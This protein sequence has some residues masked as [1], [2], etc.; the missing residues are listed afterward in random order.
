MK[1]TNLAIDLRIAT[2]VLTLISALGG[3]LSY[4]VLPKES[5]PSIEIPNII[6]TT[7]YPGASPADVENLITRRIEREVQTI[8]G[9]DKLRSTSVEGVSTI[10][11]EFTPDVKLDE[12]NQKIREKVDLAKPELPTDVEEPIISEIDLS[13]FPIMAVNLAAG[14]SLARLKDVAEDLKDSIETIPSVLEVD[15]VGGLE[16]EVQVEVDIGKL[17]GYNLGFSDISK[18]IREENTNIPGGSIDVDRLNYLIRIDGQIEHPRELEDLQIKTEDGRSIYIRDVAR[19][20]YGFKDRASHARLRVLR[21]SEPDGRLVEVG[22]PDYTQVITLSVK[23][24]SGTNIIDAADAVRAKIKEFRTPPGTKV[25]ITGDQSKGVRDLVKDLENNIISGLVFVV[26]VLLFFLGVRTSLLVG[27]AIPLSMFISFIVFNAMGQTLNFII[28]FSLIIALGMLVDNAIVIVENI[29]RFLEEGHPPWEAARNGTAEVG[30]AVIAS[31]ATTVAAFIPMLFW[32]GIIGEFMSFMPLTLIVT[33]C[34]SLFVALVI[35]P[36]ITGYFAQVPGTQSAPL[37]RNMRFVIG[38]SVATALIII[39]IARPVTVLVMLGTGLVLYLVHTRILSKVADRFVERG[40]PGLVEAYR[41]FLVLM[42]QRDYDVRRGLLR[43]AFSL[44]AFAGG[45]G[46]LALGGV[47]AGLFGQ[48]AAL[49]LLVPGGILA[50]AGLIGVLVHTFETIALGRMLSV[51]LGLAVTAAMGLALGVVALGRGGLAPEAVVGSLL[52]PV[53]VVVFGLIGALLL[54]G[55][56]RLLLTDNRARLLNTVLGGLIGILV[57]FSVAPTGVE[58]FPETDPNQILITAEARLG[59]NLEAS[60]RVARQ[61]EERLDALLSRSPATERSF[62]N[63]LVNVGVGGDAMFGGGAASPE[64]SRFTLNLVDYRDREE[65]SQ[66]TLARIREE[67]RGLAGVDITIDAD[68][69]GPP[70]GPPVNIELTGPDF[71]EIV[72][73]SAEAQSLLS[74]AAEDGSLPGLVDVRDNLNTGRPELQVR[75]NRERA[76]RFGLSTSKIASTVRTAIAG[77][78]VSKYRDGD[79][80][81]DIRL[82]LREEDRR[83][84][85]ALRQLNIFH[86]GTQI[87]LVSVAELDLGNG[88]GSITRL[89]M[90]RVVTVQGDAAPGVNAPALL[91]QVQAFLADFEARMP[92]GYMMRYTGQSDDQEKSFAFLSQ[93]LFI[94]VSLIFMILVAQFNSVSGPFMIMLAVGLSLIGVLLGLILTRTPFGLMSFIGIISL[95]G[96]VVNN[97]IVLIDYTNQ[98]RAR[99]FDKQAAIVEAGATR[100]RPVLLTALTTVLG[101]IP[102]VFGLNIDFVGYFAS[103]DP[104]FQLG[105]QNTQFWGPMG[106]AIIAGLTFG[107]FLTLVIIPVMYSL[108]DS[109]SVRL[110]RWLEDG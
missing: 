76:A 55:R 31:T 74:R 35:N 89:G 12:A 65:S 43:N 98:L 28:L 75:V 20:I 25:L 48:N 81:Y 51:K 9:I 49:V 36:V 6:I 8:S 72:R 97:N 102:L 70:T 57:V 41:R 64:R 38:L 50:A 92:P 46:V 11:V 73:L 22:E 94:G 80:E 96:I 62:E 53:T 24:R 60:D 105:S 95:A 10:V 90:Q 29:Y 107:T 93:A 15:L 32:P 17:H 58:L 14:Y 66:R 56:T 67:I 34:S 109:T 101:L 39:G 40:L 47:V 7:I 13:Q 85:D 99:G 77:E 63:V 86:E 16:R 91:G 37:G 23:K 82:R 68:Q 26:A 103:F 19:V 42:L 61:T 27:V 59:T 78:E 100:L 110:A 83:S 1:I 5:N 79:D 104:D 3:L 106:T 54:R 52:I 30:T 84:L 44:G 2:L 108:F 88:L 69:Q 18:V 21:R 33:L 45:L 87:P 71:N 4:V